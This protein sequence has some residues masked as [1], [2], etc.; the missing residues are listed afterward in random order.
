[1]SHQ[2]FNSVEKLTIMLT[3]PSETKK[4]INFATSHGALITCP[5]VVSH[6]LVMVRAGPAECLTKSNGRDIPISKPNEPDIP[7]SNLLD[8]IYLFQNITSQIYTSQT[9]PSEIYLSCRFRDG[10]IWHT[11]FAA[12]MRISGSHV[13]NL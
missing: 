2:C 1:M 3:L 10:Y 7:I 6:G 13:S 8:E 11:R 5:I 4:L 12:K 9:I